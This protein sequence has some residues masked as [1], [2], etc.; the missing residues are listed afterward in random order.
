VQEIKNGRLA[1]LAFAGF[2]CQYIATGK[3]P[4]QNL[5]DHIANPWGANFATNGISIPIDLLNSPLIK[6]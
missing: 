2:V 1:M 3:G 4:L 5:G 6:Q